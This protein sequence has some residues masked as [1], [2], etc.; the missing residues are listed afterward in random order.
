MG[1]GKQVKV[2]GKAGSVTDEVLYNYIEKTVR[3]LFKVVLKELEEKQ[4]ILSPRQQYPITRV[5]SI[6]PLDF[7]SPT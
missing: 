1:E 6:S 5:A 7:I 2:T 4:Y 3:Y